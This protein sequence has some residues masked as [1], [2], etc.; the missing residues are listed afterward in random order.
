M[1]DQAA[2]MSDAAVAAAT[3]RDWST[4]RRLLDE[5]GAA[6]LSH[7]EIVRTVGRLGTHGWWSQ[8]VTVGYER[9]IGRRAIGQRCEG[10]Y[11]AAASRT[12]GG[13]KDEALRRWQA[14]V[15]D[16]IDFAGAAAEGEPRLTASEKWRYW[17]LDLD[18]GSRVTLNF[19]DKAGGKALISVNHEKLVDTAAATR[20]K[21]FWKALLAEL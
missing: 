17:R 18:D 21:E 12:I 11:G 13:D 7:P 16:R 1:S 10:D 3:G 9:M 15:R 8:M 2:G 14:L 20:A 6:G 4:W 19:S 5:Q